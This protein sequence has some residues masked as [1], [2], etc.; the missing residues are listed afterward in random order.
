MT[1]NE[2]FENITNQATARDAFNASNHFTRIDY[3]K[4][5]FGYR[6]VGGF[7]DGTRAKVNKKFI[8][9]W[10]SARASQTK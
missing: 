8:E 5:V 4:E 9:A 7:F 3:I 10:E 2:V 6:A 1:T